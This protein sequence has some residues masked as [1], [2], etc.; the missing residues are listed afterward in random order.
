M[1]TNTYRVL[2]GKRAQATFQ[3]NFQEHKKKK[4]FK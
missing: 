2:N 3:E 4:R 1:T